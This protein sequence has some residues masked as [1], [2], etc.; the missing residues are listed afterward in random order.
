MQDQNTKPADYKALNKYKR[1]EFAKKSMVGRQFGRLTV[2]SYSHSKDGRYYWNC[3][4]TANCS[5]Q[6]VA[7]TGSLTTGNTNSCG[8]FKS[9][10]TRK[11]VV[12]HGRSATPE[13]FVWANIKERTT[14][15]NIAGYKNYG[16]RGI[17]MCA[18]W[19]DSFQNFISDLGPRPSAGHSLERID[20]DGP[21]AP[22]NCVWA[23]RKVQ[24][25]NKRSNRL[26]THDNQTK[27]VAEWAE[28]YA[29]LPWRVYLLLDKGYTI[30]EIIEREAS[31]IKLKEILT[32]AGSKPVPNR[33]KKDLP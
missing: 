12:T 11:A 2:K 10:Q 17:R 22:K 23:E 7:A 18:R 14:N 24:A 19:A 9:D 29:L 20:N 21:Y 28:Q 16:G 27:C 5:K 15:P 30:S 31:A 4:C 26:V 13:F 3:E 33:K 32:W 8:C 25:R 1:L 6:V